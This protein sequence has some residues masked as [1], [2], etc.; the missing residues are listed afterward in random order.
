[1]STRNAEASAGTDWTGTDV[2][3]APGDVRAADPVTERFV[4]CLG[5]GL[6]KRHGR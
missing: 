5:T 6:S 1:M 2:R 3:T 4:P